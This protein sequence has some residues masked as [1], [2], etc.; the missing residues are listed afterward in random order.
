MKPIPPLKTLIPF[1]AV[2]R[3][4]SCTKAAQECCVTHSAISQ[5]IKQ[6]ETYLGKPLFDR[7]KNQYTLNDVGKV[8]FEHIDAALH[9]IQSATHLATNITQHN[10]C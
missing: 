1:H 7:S 5:S 8:Y 2:A 6:L 3:H 10:P 9:S 4:L